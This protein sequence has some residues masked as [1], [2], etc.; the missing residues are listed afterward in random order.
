MEDIDVSGLTKGMVVKNYKELCRILGER[1]TS[2]AAKQ[3]QLK[4]W[5][6]RFE[7][8]RKGYKYKI[9]KIYERDYNELPNKKR[10]AWIQY[11]EPLIVDSVSR[12]GG[13]KKF[14]MGDLYSISGLANENY[15]DNPWI[16]G[17]YGNDKNTDAEESSKRGLT[18][19]DGTVVAWEL[20]YWFKCKTAKKFYKIMMPILSSMERREVISSERGYYILTADEGGEIRRREAIPSETAQ[21]KNVE[22]L[23]CREMRV[24]N[25]GAVYEGGR[26]HEFSERENKLVMEKYGWKEVVFRKRIREGECFPD[27]P[28]LRKDAILPMQRK[29]GKKVLEYLKREAVKDKKAYDR[30][31]YPLNSRSWSS[32]ALN[33]ALSDENF[34][35]IIDKLSDFLIKHR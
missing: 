35:G 30:G 3:C 2:G 16:G 8:E 15:A 31:E 13:V 29:V 21:I 26:G 23:V 9:K 20:L 28:K 1:V 5:A 4:R 11:I 25:V 22:K 12:A 6:K 14:T 19:D 17:A 7:L 18:F 24:V 27:A 32:K 34:L 10:G 33:R